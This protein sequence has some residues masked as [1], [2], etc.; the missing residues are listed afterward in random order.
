MTG[1]SELLRQYAEDRSEAAFA[2]LVR[3]HVDFVYGVALRHAR[4]THRAEDATQ[5]VFTDLARK[6]GALAQRS[7]IVGWLY[8]SARYAAYKI[9]R[10]EVRREQREQE[11]EL[12]RVAAQSAPA[13]AAWQ[14]LQPLLDE[15]LHELG[16]QDRS[17]V[18]L[19]CVKNLSFAEVGA[20]LQLSEEAAR[21]RVERALDRL[22]GRLT[23]HGVASTA[24]AV[25]LA[26]TE[27][28]AVAA[29]S[30]LAASVSTAALAAGPSL[31]LVAGLVHLMTTSKII[32]GAAVVAGALAIGAAFHET[33]R[34]EETES[35]LAALDQGYDALAARLALARQNDRAAEKE[36]ADLAADLASVQ[37]RQHAQAAT[38]GADAPG[39][40][41]PA[42]GPAAGTSADPV[43]AAAK[44][45]AL[46]E[47]GSAYMRMGIKMDG[48]AFAKILH[49]TPQQVDAVAAIEASSFNVEV[50]GVSVPGNPP[51]AA[52]DGMRQIADLVG[53][54]EA[55]QLAV[56]GRAIP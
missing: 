16:A 56:A 26:L 15:V 33:R 29:P 5:A 36:R 18:L 24:A 4:T 40:R 45:A 37:A 27:Q 10:Q 47:V 6:A 11:A 8:T 35:R 46:R 30:S 55:R 9:V 17:A 39:K 31:P 1:D 7:E 43:A 20:A 25:A 54:D 23:R 34:A 21:K 14:G 22:R 44:A 49:L 52:E 28:A 51:E 32:A 53:L 13:E 48:L 19:R 2:E 42:G 41:G 50:N 38:D 3:R 12:M